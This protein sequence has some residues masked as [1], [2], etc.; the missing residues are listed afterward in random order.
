MIVRGNVIL[1]TRAFV[2]WH[3]AMTSNCIAI[4]RADKV[5]RASV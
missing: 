2:V 5:G 3:F 4:K 1:E